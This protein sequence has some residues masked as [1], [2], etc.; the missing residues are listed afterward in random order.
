[1]YLPKYSPNYFLLELCILSHTFRGRPLEEDLYRPH[2][3]E[4]DV[5]RLL[6]SAVIILLLPSFFF[7]RE[8]ILFIDF[9]GMHTLPVYIT[10]SCWSNLVLLG[11][12]N[13]TAL[14]PGKF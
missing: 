9:K 2:G 13:P 7:Y 1:M 12:I 11:K 10:H 6:E 5:D 8:Y 3:G 4:I 14:F